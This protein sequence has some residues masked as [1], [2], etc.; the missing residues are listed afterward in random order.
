MKTQA[1]GWLMA[2]IAALG[3][4]GFYHDGGMPCL[5]QMV[6]R[7]ESRSAAVLALAGGHVDQFL[8]EARMT[9]PQ[10][11]TAPAQWD[12]QLARVQFEVA[13]ADDQFARVQAISAREQAAMAR[14]DARRAQIEARTAHRVC[15]RVPDVTLDPV[16]IKSIHLPNVNVPE[17]RVSDIRIPDVEIPAVSIPEVDVPEVN[18]PRIRV[19][20]ACTHVRVRVPRVRIPAAPAVHVDLSGAGPV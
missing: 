7:V 15:V 19:H 2:G 4:N 18:V 17:I 8:E 11:G 16:V 3:I 1:W 5:H 10:D 13:R 9:T 14:I 20:G 6:N 12:D